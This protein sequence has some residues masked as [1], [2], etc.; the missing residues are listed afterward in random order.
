MGDI[1][2]IRENKDIAAVS[3]IWILS[4]IIFSF[5]KDSAFVQFH[6]RQGSVLFVFSVI[7]WMIP[8]IGRILEIFVVAGMIMGFIYAAQGQY[9]KIPLVSDLASGKFQHVFNFFQ[10]VWNYAMNL[11]KR[12]YRKE[13]RFEFPE[14]E[15]LR[16]QDQTEKNSRSGKKD[17]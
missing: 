9:A 10:N 14:I 16:S 13:K 8:F 7:F 1:D 3:Y 4:I 11:F 5:R 15:K 2:D 17:A 6:S 12:I